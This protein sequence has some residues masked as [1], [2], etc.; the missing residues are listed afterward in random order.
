MEAVQQPVVYNGNPEPQPQPQNGGINDQRHEN[1]NHETEL[2][3]P[4]PLYLHAES[5]MELMP[6]E[7]EW[8]MEIKAAVAKDPELEPLTDFMYAQIAIVT[9]ENNPP[10]PIASVVDR[11]ARYQAGLQAHD[12]RDTYESACSALEETF[13]NLIPGHFIGFDYYQA[14]GSYVLATD[15]TKFCRTVEACPRKQD[16]HRAAATFLLH[17]Q[18][19]DFEAMRR[20]VMTLVECA[21]YDW[22]DPDMYNLTVV[23]NNAVPTFYPSR[24]RRVKFYNCGLFVNLVVS[25][26][27]RL[28]PKYVLQKLEVGCK[29]DSSRLQG[30]HNVPVER[31]DQIYVVPNIEATNKRNLDKIKACLRMRYANEG[32]FT[33]ED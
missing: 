4:R 2:S 5:R 27:K 16:T 33:F 31:L 26:A 30:P 18:Q 28:L 1:A 11:V 23:R 6:Q 8:A 12:I 14:E 9:L 17:A 32:Y 24:M 7:K 10:E 19:P 29:C 21:G 3:E 20:G 15:M 22:K 25:A 13:C